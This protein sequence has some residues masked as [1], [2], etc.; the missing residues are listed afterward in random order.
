M[1]DG[2]TKFGHKMTK[3][4]LGGACVQAI[5]VDRETGDITANADFRKGGTIDGI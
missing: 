4:A 1:V 2:L 5:L 3:Q